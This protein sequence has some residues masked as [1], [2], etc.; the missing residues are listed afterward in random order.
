MCGTRAH[1]D[2]EQD[3]DHGSGRPEC[4]YSSEPGEPAQ[5]QN[6]PSVAR[7]ARPKGAVSGR[8]DVEARP[9]ASRKASGSR[10]PQAASIC[11]PS[12]EHGVVSPAEALTRPRVASPGRDG[13]SATSMDMAWRLSNNERDDADER[14]GLVRGAGDRSHE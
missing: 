4:R 1:H 2:G 14:E 6:G 7:S 8:A 12:V 10:S 3:P 13:S 5:P 11:R 9:A